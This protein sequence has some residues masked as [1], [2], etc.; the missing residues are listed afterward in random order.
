M[1]GQDAAGFMSCPESVPDPFQ[2]ADGVEKAL[3]ELEAAAPA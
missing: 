2:I 1:S 3:A